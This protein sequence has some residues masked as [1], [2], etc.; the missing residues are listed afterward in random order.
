MVE[1]TYGFLWF[2]TADGL[3]KYDGKQCTIYRHDFTD[4]S[5]IASSEIRCMAEG[6]DGTLWIGTVYGGVDKFDRTTES[7]VHYRPFQSVVQKTGNTSSICVDRTG[8]VWFVVERPQFSLYRLNPTTGAYTLYH[9]D[10]DNPYSISSN[11]I[12]AVCMDSNGVIWVG[13]LDAGLN[14]FDSTRNGFVNH[15]TV[16]EYSFANT[17]D[18]FTLTVTGNGMLWLGRM[19]DDIVC[20]V[21]EDNGDVV[22]RPFYHSLP[23]QN[24][25]LSVFSGAEGYIWLSFV[26]RGIYVFNEHTGEYKH[27]KHNP[28]DVRSLI[29]NRVAAIHQDRR[30]N[31][32]VCTNAG[33]GKIHHQAR[34]FENILHNGVNPV[35]LTVRTLRAFHQDRDG[36]LWVGTEDGGLARKDNDTFCYYR[37]E[38]PH[39]NGWLHNTVNT[40]YRTRRGELLTGTNGGLYCLRKGKKVLQKFFPF[41]EGNIWVI[42]EDRREN[43]WIGTLFDGLFRIDSARQNVQSF[44]QYIDIPMARGEGVF[45][46]HETADE[47][48]WIGARGGL[49]QF[50]PATCSVERHYE[51][52]KNNPYSLNYNH[53][54]FIDSLSANE[55][56]L[57]TTGGGINILNTETERFQHITMAD[58]LPSNIICAM[59]RD[60]HDNWW[61]S[62]K[63]GLAKI[64]SDRKNVVSFGANN[65]VSITDFHFRTCL[66]DAQGFLYFGGTGGYIRFHPDSVSL[67]SLPPPLALTA[68]KVFDKHFPLDTPLTEKKLI[69]L[70]HDKNFFSIEFAALDMTN[71]ARNQYRYK[72]EGIDADWREAT[73]LYA[74]ASYTDVAPGLYRFVLYGTNSYGKWNT[75]GIQLFIKVEP[76]WWQ[77]WWFRTMVLLCIAGTVFGILRWRTKELNRKN[78][79]RRQMAEFQLQAVRAQMNPHFI[80][81]ALNSILGFVVA[82]HRVQAHL[83]LTKFARLIRSTLDNSRKERVTLAEETQLLQLYCEL[84]AM[85]FS[86]KF[87]FTITVDPR[88]DTNMQ[89][90]PVMLIQPFVENA[91]KHG[92]I[93]TRTDGRVDVVFRR[94]D[95][96]LLCSITDNGIGR[97]RAEQLK[98]RSFGSHVSR[99]VELIRSRLAMLE[100]LEGEDYSLDIQNAAESTSEYVGTSVTIRLPLAQSAIT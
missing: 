43:L 17:G 29:G 11:H 27:Y 79:M 38:K 24:R 26:M 96:W 69:R 62:T 63:R 1:D 78:A 86:G 92:L 100:S 47:Q 51:Y 22:V 61:I 95:T 60:A 5:T 68:F 7:F 89:T 94:E 35:G 40:V 9:H 53:V 13:T 90:V 12:S 81:N 2:G 36:T 10:P 65:G 88:L 87:A 59:Q 99:G 77:T 70:P 37:S 28:A 39:T 66:T 3:N 52:S 55:L 25:L 18:I 14:R 21:Y 20:Q 49:Y 74:I 82:N 44:L 91:I 46:L 71:P 57:G 73:A 23:E 97:Q 93:H 4:S 41:L 98:S 8:D 34:H 45:F 32:W 80:F 15:R 67:S 16:P 56:I 76:A 75:Q 30:G 31:I 64:S 72:L 33:I 42:H 83:Y 85:R 50:N 54:W 6:R 58:G 19:K 48:F 84:E